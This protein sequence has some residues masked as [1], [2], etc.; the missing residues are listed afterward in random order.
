MAVLINFSLMIG[1]IIIDA[2]NV[3]F[4]YFIFCFFFELY[5][6]HRDLHRVDRRQRQMCIRDRSLFSRAWLPR[7]G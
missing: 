3:F 1:G 2:S 6:Y 5:G 4:N 7:P